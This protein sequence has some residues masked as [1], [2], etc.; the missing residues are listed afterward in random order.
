MTHPRSFGSESEWR[1]SPLHRQIKN[2]LERWPSDQSLGSESN[3]PLIRRVA[4]FE[5]PPIGGTRS[6]WRRTKRLR[7][8]V[9]ALRLQRAEVEVLRLG[10]KAM[11]IA[12]APVTSVASSRPCAVIFL[13]DCH[14]QIIN[15][16]ISV[17]TQ[18]A[19]EHVAG[20]KI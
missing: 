9:S 15:P 4:R 1:Q 12:I 16:D 19:E 14:D 5:E 18:I 11:S 10:S 3:I 7:V 20:R 8:A 6:E 13:E 17:R 2:V